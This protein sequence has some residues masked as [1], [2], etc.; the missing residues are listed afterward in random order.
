M[1]EPPAFV[2]I[3]SRTIEPPAQRK[4]SPKTVP[5]PPFTDAVPWKYRHE[6]LV[7]ASPTSESVSCARLAVP[8]AASAPPPVCAELSQPRAAMPWFPH[9]QAVPLPSPKQ[10]GVPAAGGSPGTGTATGTD[11][12]LFHSSRSS[13]PGAGGVGASSR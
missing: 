6:E 3:A 5:A 8:F 13:V 11:P 9:G 10:K 7:I 12:L 1:D 4:P 2:R